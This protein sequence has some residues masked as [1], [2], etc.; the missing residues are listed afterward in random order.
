[1]SNEPE[2]RNEKFETPK[3]LG[4]YRADRDDFSRL[5]YLFVEEMRVQKQPRENGA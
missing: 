4:A 3:G 1:M 5:L 2:I